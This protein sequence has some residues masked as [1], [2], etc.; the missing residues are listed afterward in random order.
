LT[1]TPQLSGPLLKD[2]ELSGML[3]ARSGFPID[4]V[5]TENL[6]GTGFDDIG[7]PNLVPGVPIWIQNHTI[8]GRRLNPDAFAV[9]PGVQGSLGRNA[10]AGFGMAQLDLA[11]A[12]VLPLSP[13][14]NV[15]LRFEAF[16]V[17]NHVNPA[18]PVRFL[19]STIFGRPPS[20]LNLMLGTGTARSG[21]APAF[22]IGGPR[23]LQATIRFQF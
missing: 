5:A 21:V 19:D 22:Q 7:R 15:Q 16:N 4:V 20:M 8:G 13:A 11:L 9:A 18:D 23:S 1:F 3:R 2:W 6:L 14:A 17:F 10:I 12:R